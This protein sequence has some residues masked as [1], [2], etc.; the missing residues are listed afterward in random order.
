MV[1][2]R[3]FACTIDFVKHLLFI[4]VCATFCHLSNFHCLLLKNILVPAPLIKPCLNR[5]APSSYDILIAS[6]ISHSSQ[7]DSSYFHSSKNCIRIIITTYLLCLVS[8]TDY[9]SSFPVFSFKCVQPSTVNS[10][11]AKVIDF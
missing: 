7:R 11:L 2:L 4:L 3:I 1:H 8:L 9:S 6:R 10:P 5:A